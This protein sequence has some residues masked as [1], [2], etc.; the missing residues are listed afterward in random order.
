MTI[1]L[2]VV[3]TLMLVW[4]SGLTILGLILLRGARKSA[5]EVANVGGTVKRYVTFIENER[6][7]IAG[8]R[9]AAPGTVPGFAF[10]AE[11]IQ[12]GGGR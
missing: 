7:R 8:E 11:E 3:I 6:R 10:E 12:K 9:G 5:Q 2:V 1:F 4:L